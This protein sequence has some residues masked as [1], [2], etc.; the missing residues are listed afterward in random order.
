MLSV[1]FP[2]QS[3]Q[4]D[5]TETIQLLSEDDNEPLWADVPSGLVVTLVVKSGSRR[6]MGDVQAPFLMQQA[7]GPLPVIS[8][9]STD[10][11]GLIETYE[12]GYVGINVPASVLSNLAGGYYEV[13]IKMT[14]DMATTQILRGILP[15]VWGA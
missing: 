15:L 1:N 4:A 10:G 7:Q 9:L 3:N 8:A 12:S 2:Q 5:W 11:S 13:F 14:D 6:G